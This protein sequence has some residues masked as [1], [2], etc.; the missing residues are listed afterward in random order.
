MK[1]K[2]I[3]NTVDT[4][5]RDQ[6]DPLTGKDHAHFEGDAAQNAYAPPKQRP[7]TVDVRL[8]IRSRE[9]A[10]GDLAIYAALLI[11]LQAVV[12]DGP[13][14]AKLGDTSKVAIDELLR[15]LTGALVGDPD[16]R[17]HYDAIAG[18]ATSAAERL[19]P[20]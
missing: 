17:D 7:T 5:M 10:H 6:L 1:M 18:Y 2:D 9:A 14:W 12:R 8:V 20:K 13:N 16:L 3:L 11:R 19:L 15:A 4:D